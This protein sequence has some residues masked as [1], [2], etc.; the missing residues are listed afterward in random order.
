MRGWGIPERRCTIMH[1]FAGIAGFHIIIFVTKRSRNRFGKYRIR[2]LFS[3]SDRG[4][5]MYHT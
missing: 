1:F 5:E 4:S 2:R 3:S